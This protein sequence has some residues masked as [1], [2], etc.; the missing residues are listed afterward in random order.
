MKRT[1]FLKL[2]YETGPAIRDK[3]LKQFRKDM[4]KFPQIKII[5]EFEPQAAVNIEFDDDQ[6][7][8]IYE[9]LCK[10]DVVEMIDPNVLKDDQIKEKKE[11]LK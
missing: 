11:K 8:T 5:K 9:V 1:I 3:V 4:T 6:Y 10:I 2:G 7:Q